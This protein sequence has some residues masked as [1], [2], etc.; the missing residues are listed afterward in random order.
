[1]P[2]FQ[3][4]RIEKT[5]DFTGLHAPVTCVYDQRNPVWA[6]H[7]CDERIVV[8][9]RS[10]DVEFAQHRCSEN[11]DSRTPVQHIHCDVHAA[12]VYCRSEARFPVSATP[13]PA[14]IDQGRF[15]GKQF[16][17]AFEVA[18]S[19]RD[20]IADEVRYNGGLVL[21]HGQVLVLGVDSVYLRCSFRIP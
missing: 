1:M 3:S 2:G 6:F 4:D 21:C 20:E 15:F 16:S 19:T 8:D 13:V 9:R 12:H 11:I 14:R 5:N 18:I 17:H 10:H 7:N